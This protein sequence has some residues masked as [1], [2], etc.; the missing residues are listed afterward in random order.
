[1]TEQQAPRD[2][3][4]LHTAAAL[5]RAAKKARELALRT[6][7]PLVVYRDGKVEKQMI[8]REEP[9]S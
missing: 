3:D 2:Q 8:V 6:Q 4:M 5:K 9:P 7:T 1:M